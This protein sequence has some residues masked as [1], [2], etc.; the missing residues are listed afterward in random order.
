MR[1]D[2]RFKN[3]YFETWAGYQQ[4]IADALTTVDL[5]EINKA[6]HFLRDAYFTGSRIFA[7]GNGGSASISEHLSCD[8]MKGCKVKNGTLQTI[9]LTSNVA[10]MTAIANDIS[11]EKIFSY[12]LELYKATPEDVLILIS[13]SGN[14]GNIIDALHWAKARR[15]TTIGFSGFGGGVLK[16]LCDV[17]LHVNVSNYGVVEDAHQSLMHFLAQSQYLAT[18][19]E[20]SPPDEG[21]A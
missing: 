16:T 12:Q 4:A 8:F 20:I 6:H 2:T 13:S 21:N 14:S 19:E 5:K 7:A 17:S 15:V 10:L 1:T 9:P 11:Y 3:K 18:R